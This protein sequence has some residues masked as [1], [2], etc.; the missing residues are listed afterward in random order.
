MVLST[1]FIAC[2]ALTPGSGVMNRFEF[3]STCFKKGYEA[4]DSAFA[5]TPILSP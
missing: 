5:A 4:S 2:F 1:A 3:Q